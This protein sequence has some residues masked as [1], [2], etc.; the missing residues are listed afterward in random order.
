VI[1]RKHFG[2]EFMALTMK[3]E[4][5]LQASRSDVWEALNNPEILRQSIPGCETLKEDE[6]GNLIATATV[7]IGPIKAKFSG[8]VLFSDVVPLEGYKISGEGQG[9][10]AGFA[11]GGAS[12][13]LSEIDPSHTRL[14]YDV[15]ADV[16]GKIAQLGGRLLNSVAKKYADG[17]FESFAAA[18]S[19][20]A[21]A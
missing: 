3:G 20:R 9:G 21:A 6:Q 4:I 13:A 19:N 17:F 12:V 18:L 15:E 7:K 8:K 11:K 1:S 2:G 16:G 14:T 10:L 5:D